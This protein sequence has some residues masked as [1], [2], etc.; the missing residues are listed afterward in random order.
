MDTIVFL[1]P[2][3]LLAEA[4]KIFPEACYHAPAQ[5]G[6]ILRALRL[7]PKK[8][9]LIDGYFEGRASVWHKEILFALEKGVAVYGAGSMGALRAAELADFGMRGVGKVFQNYR[10]CFL[11]NDDAVAVL[12][13][14]RDTGYVQ[15]NEALVDIQASLEKAHKKKFISESKKEMLLRTITDW[16]YPDRNLEHIYNE[17]EK[18][19]SP[20]QEFSAWLQRNGIVKQK[21]LD[22]IEALN[23]A[24]NEKPS[25]TAFPEVP[26][27]VHFRNLI[28]NVNCSIFPEMYDWLTQEERTLIL[29]R[30]EDPKFFHALL[31]TAFILLVSYD[32]AQSFPFEE[33]KLSSGDSHF[34]NPWQ[35]SLLCQNDS[36]LRSIYLWIFGQLQISSANTREVVKYFIYF[37]HLFG[38]NLKIRPKENKFQNLI[39][40]YSLLFFAIDQFLQNSQFLFKKNNKIN[41]KNLTKEF[42]QFKKIARAIRTLNIPKA[43]R[44]DLLFKIVR[45]KYLFKGSTYNNIA[46]VQDLEPM[47]WV[48]RAKHAIDREDC[49]KP[50]LKLLDLEEILYQ[51]PLIN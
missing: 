12:H 31:E 24:R 30:S 21:T 44:K 2:T 5:C 4:K 6:D 35:K 28:R 1:G 38:Y 32:L 51:N 20:F 11:D 34:D 23:R 22:A 40:Q 42:P 17:A 26:K 19:G 9:L 14:D 33:R 7:K 50:F 10:S 39:S 45:F 27:T 37:A 13:A 8:I 41:L 18:K 29:E 43:D 36:W 46:L 15:M 47:N 16:F 48:L 49:F 3:L 25:H